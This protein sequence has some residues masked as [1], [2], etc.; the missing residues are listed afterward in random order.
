MVG[1]LAGFNASNGRTMLEGEIEA[2]A[3]ALAEAALN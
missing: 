1:A 2:R 3:D